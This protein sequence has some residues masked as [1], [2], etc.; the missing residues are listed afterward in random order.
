MDNDT[1]GLVIQLCT[2]VGMI[3]EDT[4]VLALTVRGMDQVGQ[5]AALR[6]IERAAGRIHALVAAAKALKS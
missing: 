4:S 5:R 6:K 1:E 2:Q 3:M